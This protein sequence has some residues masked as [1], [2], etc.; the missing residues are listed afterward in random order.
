MRLVRFTAIALAA[1]VGLAR[2]ATD[3]TTVLRQRVLGFAQANLGR[4]IGN[5][6]CAGLAFQA[7]KAAGAMPK[8]KHG[9][10]TPRD[11]VWG[12]QILLAEGAPGGPKMTGSLDAVRPGDVAQF[13]NAQFRKAHMAHHT[14][15]V[16][17]IS[18]K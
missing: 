5:G 7:L 18:A 11:Y 10:P 15:I 16:S 8:G 12:E 3:P 1:S 14:A 9:Y 17:D 4:K 6:E 2:A 13:S